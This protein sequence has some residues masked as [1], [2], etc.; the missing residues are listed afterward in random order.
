MTQTKEKARLSL[1]SF[2]QDHIITYSM[3]YTS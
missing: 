3:A 1:F 2:L